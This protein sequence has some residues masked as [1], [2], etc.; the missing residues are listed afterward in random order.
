MKY[1]PKKSTKWSNI[2]DDLDKL[3]ILSENK[4]NLVQVCGRE[5]CTIFHSWSQGELL[6]LF[7][8][9]YDQHPGPRE[10]NNPVNLST[11]YYRNLDKKSNKNYFTKKIIQYDI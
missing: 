9:Q 7:T 8:A 1:K 6:L 5:L 10:I 4:D 3:N 2:P 11:S